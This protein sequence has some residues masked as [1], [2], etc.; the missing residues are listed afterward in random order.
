MIL[1]GTIVRI[2]DGSYHV[3]V[4]TTGAQPTL[5]AI[6]SNETTLTSHMSMTE[7]HG[8]TSLYSFRVNYIDGLVNAFRAA[9]SGADS[10]LFP[11]GLE[12]VVDDD[13]N[14]T[15]ENARNNPWEAR[16]GDDIYIVSESAGTILKVRR[17]ARENP[18]EEYPSPV[19]GGAGEQ[20]AAL[21]LFPENNLVKPKYLVWLAPALEMGSAG[22]GVTSGEY[23]YLLTMAIGDVENDSD[24]IQLPLYSDRSTSSSIVGYLGGWASVP[25]FDDGLNGFYAILTRD[26]E[27]LGIVAY[28][29]SS[30]VTPFGYRPG[31]GLDSAG[32]EIPERILR[33][34]LTDSA[35]VRHLSPSVAPPQGNWYR[36]V[37][38]GVIIEGW[39]VAK[40]S[41]SYVAQL[42]LPS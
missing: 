17:I 29:E 35:S 39:R 6:D 24:S 33:A 1:N 36:V 14:E 16:D 8:V 42:V 2:T 41:S 7:E 15:T 30:F 10:K 4:E 27:G 19:L 22:S 23:N 13:G 18:S 26:S 20:C 21:F 5:A 11:I 28:V 38:A 12:T 9:V 32:S 34:D 37:P 3:E 31:S 40:Y 25:R